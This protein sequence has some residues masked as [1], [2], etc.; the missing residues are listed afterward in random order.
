MNQCNIELQVAK[1]CRTSGITWCGSWLIIVVVVQPCCPVVPRFPVV[2]SY[3]VVP[4]CPIMPRRAMVPRNPV[5]PKCAVVPSY[6]R[7]ERTYLRDY[8]SV[9]LALCSSTL[10]RLVCLARSFPVT[11]VIDV[12]PLTQSSTYSPTN[13]TWLIVGQ[14]RLKLLEL[15]TTYT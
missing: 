3:P 15:F 13:F 14:L 12:E 10:Y 1:F 9:R 6:P 2:P 4:R 5:V 7:V 8:K 11:Y